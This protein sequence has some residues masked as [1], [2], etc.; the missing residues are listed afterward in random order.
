MFRNILLN[1]CR[2]I[3]DKMYLSILYCWHIKQRMN[4]N[5]PQGFNAKLQWLKVHDRQVQYSQLVDKIS[6]KEYVK[7]QLGDEYVIPT[8]GVYNRFDDIDLEKLPIQFVLK[9]NHDGGGNSVILC[10]DRN[11]L[12]IRETRKIINKCLARN[13]YW[14]GREFCYKNIRPQILIEEYLEDS[15]GASLN[16]YKFMVF[17]GKVKCSFVCSNR[18]IGKKVNVTFFDLNWNKLPFER[19]HPMDM[20]NIPKP[21]NYDKMIELSEKLASSIQVEFVR[22]DFYEVNGRIYFG[23][24][25]FY[26]GSGFEAFQPVEWDKVLGSWINLPINN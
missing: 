9:C 3:P 12:N 23:E 10:K 20:N 11:K 6:V 14:Y 22:I 2:C 16:D 17:G 1:L 4:W 19:S 7:T 21:T 8:L 25:T 18:E 15:G 26:P 24:I 5:C 13:A